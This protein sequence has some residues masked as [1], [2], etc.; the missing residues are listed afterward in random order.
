MS[1]GAELAGA[2]PHGRG[3]AA[4]G[5]R[6]RHLPGGQVRQGWPHPGVQGPAHKQPGGGGGRRGHR[7]GRGAQMPA[8]TCSFGVLS[9]DT[10]IALVALSPE[11]SDPMRSPGAGADPPAL[12]LRER[13]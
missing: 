9:L 6:C 1:R 5:A 7:P 12:G 8:D 4:A 13:P 3:A 11:Q 10:T 2:G